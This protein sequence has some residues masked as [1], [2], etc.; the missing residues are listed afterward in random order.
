MRLESKKTQEKYISILERIQVFQLWD[1]K[2]DN[3]EFTISMYEKIQ[4]LRKFECRDQKYLNEK[5]DE[6]DKLLNNR[7]KSYDGLLQLT[8]IEFVKNLVPMSFLPCEIY[9]EK[10][11]VKNVET[12][13]GKTAKMKVKELFLTNNF[14]ELTVKNTIYELGLNY[15]AD[16]RNVGFA[17]KNL[18]D[19]GVLKVKK[20]PH[21]YI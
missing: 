17:L 11:M 14:E 10:C 19:E 15:N 4:K 8:M 1:G 12:K 13:E 5:L 7:F 3:I 20:M 2:K 6:I 18:T 9:L 21:G 16:R